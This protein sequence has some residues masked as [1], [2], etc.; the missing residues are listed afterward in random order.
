MSCNVFFRA[1][2]LALWQKRDNVCVS[3]LHVQWEDAAA[4]A[5]DDDDAFVFFLTAMLCVSRDGICDPN[6]FVHHFQPQLWPR[7][8]YVSVNCTILSRVLHKVQPSETGAQVFGNHV[9][10]FCRHAH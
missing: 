5:D 3:P 6:T 1:V 10:D 4:A 8:V 7:L 2:R 9:L